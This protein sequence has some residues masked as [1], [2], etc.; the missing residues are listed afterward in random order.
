MSDSEEEVA[1]TEKILK[2]VVVGDGSSGKTS[3]CK[4]FAQDEFARNY[5]QTLGLD[6]YSKRLTLPGDVQ[7]LLQVWD[8]GGQ[9]ISGPMIDKY[10][11][12]CHAI[13][14]VYDVTNASSFENLSDWVSVV[15]RITKQQEKPPLMCLVG[16]KTDMEH[17][18]NVRIE[19]HTKFIE[20]NQ[21]TGHYVSAKT[22]DSVT[23]MFRQMAAEVLGIQ[24]SKADMESDIIVVN[25]PITATKPVLAEKSN[26][27][28]KLPIDQAKNSAV[29][30]I[31]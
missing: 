14:L 4:R 30:V 31:Q 8:I 28:K 21:L 29:C 3:I 11:F 15:K 24:L 27:V 19:K 9:S 1:S 17:R 23:L 16:N 25:A 7:V 10:V 2:I 22:G 20:Q 18:R 5:Q 13:V 6:F 12:G 26:S